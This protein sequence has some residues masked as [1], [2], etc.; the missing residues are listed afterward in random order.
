M[1]ESCVDSC[2]EAD[3][4][5]RVA[6][7]CSS[8]QNIATLCSFYH[9]SNIDWRNANRCRKLNVFCFVYETL[10]KS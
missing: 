10:I 3:Y 7:L 8:F 6:A 2:S 1:Y 5:N 9:S 4:E